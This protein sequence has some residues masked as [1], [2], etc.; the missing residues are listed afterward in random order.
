MKKIFLAPL[1]AIVISLCAFT[2]S[3][4]WKADE[5]NST[6]KWELKGSDKTGS[7]ENLVTTLDFDKKNLDKSK[8]TA[9]IDV[10]TLKAGNEKLEKHLLSADFF[11]AGK[12]PRIVFTSTEIKSTE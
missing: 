12:F 11:D 4:I 3:H 7:F 10:G 2:A 9:S 6:V 5:K 1:A 8:I